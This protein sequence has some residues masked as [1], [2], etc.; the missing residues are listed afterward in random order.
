MCLLSWVLTDLEF[1]GALEPLLV[2]GTV[3]SVH[4]QAHEYGR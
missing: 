2:N 3:A 4:A 1:R